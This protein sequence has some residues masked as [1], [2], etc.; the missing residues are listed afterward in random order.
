[1]LGDETRFWDLDKGVCWLTKRP[2]WEAKPSLRSCYATST[3][4]C[5][6]F[7]QDSNIGDQFGSLVPSSCTKNS[8]GEIKIF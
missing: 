3:N 1:M 5:C 8:F 4:A 6:N 7:I 2:K